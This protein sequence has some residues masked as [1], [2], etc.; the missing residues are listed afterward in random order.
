MKPAPVQ[1]EPDKLAPKKAVLEDKEDEAGLDM[2]MIEDDSDW[3]LLINLII[4]N[5]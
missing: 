4:F 1:P 2:P 5:T 3:I